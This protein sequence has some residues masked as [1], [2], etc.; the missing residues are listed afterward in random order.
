MLSQY[1]HRQPLFGRCRRLDP[2]EKATAFELLV[3]VIGMMPS[4]PPG[5]NRTDQSAAAAGKRRG[6]DHRRQS[7]AGCYDRPRSDKST[8]VNQSADQGSFRAANG[9]C[10]DVS[11]TRRGGIIGQG[12]R[13]LVAMPE[14]F[15]H[16]VVAGEQAQVG[17]VEARAEKLIAR[18]VERSGFMKDSDRFPGHLGRFLGRHLQI[19][20]VGWE[21]DAVKAS[22]S[23][24]ANCE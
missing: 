22:I 21:P 23:A 17:P 20:L 3:Q 5:E 11:H 6:S 16:G 19:S 15:F 4:D 1:F 13:S 7:A 10:R 2:K 9:L 8:D 14:L 12:A 18:G 24:R